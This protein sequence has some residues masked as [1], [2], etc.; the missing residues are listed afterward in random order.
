M[1]AVGDVGNW[2]PPH[3]GNDGRREP[4]ILEL[5]VKAAP[6][7]V[8]G[9]ARS[10]LRATRRAGACL[11][12]G[13]STVVGETRGAGRSVWGFWWAGSERVC[14]LRADFLPKSRPP[15]SPPTP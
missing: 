4:G 11:H 8:P 14:R 13:T 5:G 15:G 6:A 3:L 1:E 10:Q 7:P 2:L 12:K 9:W